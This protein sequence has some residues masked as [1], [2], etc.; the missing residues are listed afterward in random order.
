MDIHMY[1]IVGDPYICEPVFMSKKPCQLALYIDSCRQTLVIEVMST[2]LMA[3]QF[4][5]I[6][7]T[8]SSW[9]PPSW[10]Q[11][12]RTKGSAKLGCFSSWTSPFVSCK[13]ASSSRWRLWCSLLLL[14]CFFFRRS[15]PFSVMSM[16]LDESKSR[17]W[18]S[19]TV[20]RRWCWNFWEKML[21]KSGA[22][23]RNQVRLSIFKSFV[24]FP[25]WQSVQLTRII[26]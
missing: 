10:V 4:T 22:V 11:W 24:T 13:T 21:F 16:S 7:P 5:S 23:S 14:W 12:T 17:S 25:R 1:I 20:S 6:G 3:A 26:H 8:S 9:T 19:S 15:V 2:R 18:A